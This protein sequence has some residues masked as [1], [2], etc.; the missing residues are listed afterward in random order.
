MG[1]QYHSS[2]TR[3]RPFFQPLLRRD[4]QG[5]SWLPDLLRMTHANPYL[6]DELADNAG[7]LLDW[8]ARPRMRPDR[9][10][11]LHGIPSVELQDC[12]EYR[13][14]PPPAFLRWLIEKPHALLWPRDDEMSGLPQRRRE[15]LFGHHGFAKQKAAQAEAL[16][17]LE[18]AGAAGSNGKWWAFEGFTRVD[19]LLETPTLVLLIEGKRTEPLAQATRWFPQRNQV[20]RNLEVARTVAGEHNKNYAVILLAEDYLEALA[21]ESGEQSLPHLPLKA[22]AEIMSH[23]LGC[24]SWSH[25]LAQMYF[26]QTVAQAA[27]RLHEDLTLTP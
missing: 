16:T 10:L 11:R 15:E 1:N 25:A 18:R 22:R 26:P 6:A 24:I 8:V 12:F 20:V 13:L 19:C 17:E 4:P 14:P 23:Y 3:V 9:A 7:P 5:L 21:L 2:I 27:R